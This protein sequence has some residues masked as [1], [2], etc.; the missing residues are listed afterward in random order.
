MRRSAPEHPTIPPVFIGGR[1]AKTAPTLEASHQQQ[2]HENQDDQPHSS[3]RVIPPTSAIG[4]SRKRADQ[5]QY[6]YH[7]KDCSHFIPSSVNR[8]RSVSASQ[9]AAVG[10]HVP[11]LSGARFHSSSHWTTLPRI[12]PRLSSAQSRRTSPSSLLTPHNG[13]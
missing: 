2:D 12:V 6:Q 13:S 11:F 1:H 3:A 7:N 8:R 4:P 10:S 5:Q 9:A